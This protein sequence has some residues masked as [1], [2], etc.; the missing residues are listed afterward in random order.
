MS[1]LNINYDL[2]PYIPDI[3]IK[4]N[5][6]N[7]FDSV[8]INNSIGINTSIFIFNINE[9]ITSIYNDP[10]YLLFGIKKSGNVYNYPSLNF[11]SNIN[12]PNKTPYET[13]L[14]IFKINNNIKKILES[15]GYNLI[16]I[17]ESEFQYQELIINTSLSNSNLKSKI[18]Y[19][20]FNFISNTNLRTNYNKYASTI[21]Y[22]SKYWNILIY[23]YI[24]YDLNNPYISNNIFYEYSLLSNISTKKIMDKLNFDDRENIKYYTKIDY[25]YFE[26]TEF[27]MTDINNNSHIETLR[28]VSYYIKNYHNYMNQ[29]YKENPNIIYLNLNEISKIFYPNIEYNH[30]NS[31]TYTN[32]HLNDKYINNNKCYSSNINKYSYSFDTKISNLNFIKY[33]NKSYSSYNYEKITNSTLYQKFINYY[34]NSY[35][36]L[37]NNKNSLAQIN[38]NLHKIFVY[39]NPKIIDLNYL[40][41]NVKTK[42]T[43]LFQDSN[44][45]EFGTDTKKLQLFMVGN[46]KP[47]ELYYLSKY[48][49]EFISENNQESRLNFSYVIIL[50]IIFFD[51]DKMNI[52]NKSQTLTMNE[53]AYINYT[54]EENTVSLSPTILK[55]NENLSIY[56]IMN[57]INITDIKKYMYKLDYSFLSNY[58]NQNNFIQFINFYSILTNNQ[59]NLRTSTNPSYLYKNIINIKML[60]IN[61]F[62][63]NFININDNFNN[64]RSIN[65]NTKTYLNYSI[66]YDE[67]IIKNNENSNE[68]INNYIEYF[69]YFPK[70][71]P[72]YINNPNYYGK[73]YPNLESNNYIILPA[74]KYIK[75]NYINLISIYPIFPDEKI[76]ENFVKSVKNIFEIMNWNFSLL[77]KIPYN[78]NM[79]D[80]LY[81]SNLKYFWS[82]QYA[83]NIGGNHTNIYLVLND[84]NNNPYSF[85]SD[86]DSDYGII[87]AIKIFNY[88]NFIS[89]NLS[90]DIKLNLFYNKYINLS[91]LI[92]LSETYYNYTDKN[93]IIWNIN[94]SFLKLHNIMHLKEIL[95][96]DLKRFQN[97]Y[98][99]NEIVE[100]MKNFNYKT[101]LNLFNNKL[102]LNNMRYDIKILIYISNLFK[103]LNLIKKCYNYCE[104]ISTNIMMCCY[105]NDLLIDLVKYN[106][107]IIS[108]LYQIN[109]DLDISSGTFDTLIYNMI[110]KINTIETNNN[111]EN[112]KNYQKELIYILN[113]SNNK[114]NIILNLVG[115]KDINNLYK[116]IYLQIYELVAFEYIN[117][118]YNLEISNDIDNLISETN[119]SK[120]HFETNKKTLLLKQI[121]AYLKILVFNLTKIDELFNLILLMGNNTIN[122][123]LFDLN[124]KVVKNTYIYNT[125][126]YSNSSNIPTFDIINFLMDTKNI[127]IYS[128]SS[129]NNPITYENYQKSIQQGILTFIDNT[130]TNFSSIIDK[131][132]NIYKY[133]RNIPGM[134]NINIYL[135]DEIGDFYILLTEFNI[136]YNSMFD[137]INENKINLF[138]EYDNLFNSFN[139]L[140]YSCQEFLLSIRLWNDFM[141]PTIPNS[142]IFINEDLYKIISV[143]VFKD[144]LTKTINNF[145]NFII[146][147]NPDTLILYLEKMSKNIEMYFI[148]KFKPHI[149]VTLNKMLSQLKI[150]SNNNIIPQIPIIMYGSYYII[151]YAD[152]LLFKEKLLPS[153]FNFFNSVLTIINSIDQI[154]IAIFNIYYNNQ[155]GIPYI[156]ALG[157]TY[158]STPYKYIN[159]DNGIIN[160]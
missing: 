156:N 18:I 33:P 103:T 93:T 87:Y 24:N 20:Y 82:N 55:C 157:Y 79:D 43:P 77:I 57:N 41:S 72:I 83:A 84:E 3:Y 127:I 85:Y 109:Y 15:I 36:D 140:F 25:K 122:D 14:P 128:S 99:K 2:R 105:N 54:L 45:L 22:D 117:Y 94:N 62:I 19:L 52:L 120:C 121:E 59:I 129:I 23:P 60:K 10:S 110:S 98:D 69:E 27:T 113:Y 73:Y 75:F 149:I 160:E 145:Y 65:S 30:I 91:Q 144:F 148:N 100:Q 126:C 108:K 131:I 38:I 130:I 81:C 111:L 71:S 48:K 28:N 153:S 159:I 118:N 17:N 104:I 125:Q 1:E 70:I 80:N 114:I 39:I 86:S 123:Y 74:G 102:Q 147:K 146:N 132:V 155:I 76:K 44:L 29:T 26:N 40:L 137:I 53:L 32:I 150:Q 112:I 143:D 90:L 134:S 154:N 78:I 11:F 13:T 151:P 119:L 116:N 89:P 46:F 92:I 12:M 115:E 106:I 49:I 141:N 152:L 4:D 37:V 133:M 138:M 51:S 95:T 42:I 136:N 58:N 21:Y 66:L 6:F 142:N 50:G 68:D 107:N 88:N 56:E 31:N 96:F 67:N 124:L 101:L 5:I 34:V 9:P 8:N 135:P 64:F 7:S 47:T 97:N 158:L 63:K 61:N 16:D 139:N 35:F